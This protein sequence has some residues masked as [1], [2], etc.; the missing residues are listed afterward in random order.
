MPQILMAQPIVANH[1]CTDLSQIP[2]N[3][4]D[5]AQSKLRI[6]YGH[7]SHG[8]QLVTGMDALLTY[9]GD[10]YNFNSDGSGE[11]LT[12]H[13]YAMGGDVGCYPAWVDNTY[14]YLNDTANS[15]VNVIIWSWCGQAAGYDEQT[16]ID[17]YLGPMSQLEREYPNVK[18][19][20]M[21]C[22]LDGSGTEGNLNIRDQQ[23]RDFCLDSNKILF[24]F[25]DI[26]SYDPDGLVNYMELYANDNCD[27]DSSGNTVNWAQ[28]WI[29]A[30]PGSELAQEAATICEGCCVHSQGLNCARKGRAV[31]WLWARLAGWD[32]TSSGVQR[33]I[34]DVPLTFNVS[35]NYPNPF[36][37]A[38]TIE[39]TLAE[40]SRVTLKIYNVLGDKIV[41]LVDGERNAGVV[42]RVQFNASKLSSGVY[43]Y[44]LE[45]EKGTQV[46]KL[47]LMK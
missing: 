44:R 30:N 24:D 2:S 10:T 35:Q 8:S 34:G 23:I 28:T 16:M 41:T 31:W 40:N 1:L 13:D 18:F 5:S 42:H 15:D 33:Q 26:E 7:T 6:A 47:L 19:V 36:N 39:F 25:V 27:Y 4:I 46:R 20:Y 17:A 3:W 14:A 29:A 43:F 45:T 9:H 12:L 11:A 22:H 32:G 37:P 21:T 38:T